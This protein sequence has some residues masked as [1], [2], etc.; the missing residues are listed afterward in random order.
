MSFARQEAERF[1]HDYIGPEH[2]LLGLVKEGS[3]VAAHVLGNLEVDLEKI[4][5]EVEKLIK[6][7]PDVVTIGQLPFTPRGKKVLEFAIDE[8]RALFHNYVGTEHLLLG[9]LRED[10]SPT[11]QVFKN[12]GLKLEEVRSEVLE[13]LGS[14]QK[15]TAKDFPDAK[16]MYEGFTDRSQVVMGHAWEWAERFNH[17]GICTEHILLGIVQ[18]RTGVAANVLTRMGIDL[19]EVARQ[20][21]QLVKYTPDIVTNGQHPL[22]W[23]ARKV[24]EFANDESRALN[25]TIVGTEHLLLGLLRENEG[26][27]AR[28]LKGFGLI[29]EIV[30]NKIVEF[31]RIEPATVKRFDVNLNKANIDFNVQRAVMAAYR[32]AKSNGLDPVQLE[33]V[34]LGI[35]SV[36]DS[37]AAKVLKKYGLELD[38]VRAEIIKL[39]N[40]SSDSN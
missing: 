22:T 23:R 12:M 31:H 27:A 9:L 11:A 21:K 19:D 13:F 29:I 39:R 7:G 28:A 3:G 25:H 35:L 6:P 34:L 5:L 15:V 36:P 2:I 14:E 8:A 38:T 18:E 33:H 37:L 17:D 20:I 30:R 4:R 10:Q 16:S 1:H 40:E 26:H 24:I 32:E